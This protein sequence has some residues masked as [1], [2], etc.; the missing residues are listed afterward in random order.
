MSSDNNSNFMIKSSPH[1]VDTDTTPR[2]M[3]SVLLALLPPTASAV[4]F[5]GPR[6]LAV[7][8]VSIISALL[9]ETAVL[10]IRGKNINLHDGSAAVTGL[11]LALCLPPE[12][13][14]TLT[15]LGAIVAILLGKQLFGGLGDNI[16]NPALVGRVFLQ[17][18]FPA[19]MTTWAAPFFYQKA[20]SVTGATP[21]AQA[22]YEDIELVAGYKDLFLGNVGGS[23]GETSALAI[24]I[25]GIYLLVR[26]HIDWRIPLGYLG[27]V[28]V[29]GGIFH[30][31]NPAL[32]SP[33]FHL[34]AGGL[35]FGAF[36]MATDMVTTPITPTGS[37]IFAFGCGLLVVV[38]RLFGGADEG[39][40][41]SILLM[42]SVTPLIDRYTRPQMFGK[43][44]A[45]R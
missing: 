25:G 32:P 5:F 41:F 30:L 29:L 31:F 20:Q 14:L 2:I 15:A 42:N 7:I 3:F 36:F 10:Y 6:A 28:F 37:W 44:E 45:A 21:L 1:F 34:L 22:L 18:A 43:K 19:R 8:L 13:P 17:A 39:V 40:M 23:L 16:F 35:L 4:Y 9:T 11:L 24:L 12:F 27:T 38:I 33:F 26:G